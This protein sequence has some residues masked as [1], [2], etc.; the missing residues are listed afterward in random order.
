MDIGNRDVTVDSLNCRPRALNDGHGISAC[1]DFDVR[2]SLFSCKGL[3]SGDVKPPI[4]FALE[5]MVADIFCDSYNFAGGPYVVLVFIGEVASNRI[6][7]REIEIRERLIDDCDFGSSL[8]VLLADGTAAQNR[9]TDGCKIIRPYL[10]ETRGEI[11]RVS[12]MITFGFDASSRFGT[13]E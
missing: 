3:K 8:V 1:P 5:I 12:R 13:A 9:D 6:P 11:T 4:D 2:P 10:I 7:F